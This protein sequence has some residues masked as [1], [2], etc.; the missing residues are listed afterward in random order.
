MTDLIARLRAWARRYDPRSPERVLFLQAADELEARPVVREQGIT[1]AAVEEAL[2]SPLLPWQR[3]RL[4][5]QG[6]G[7]P[8]SPSAA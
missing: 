3:K 1:I 2:G 8:P 6:K 5:E 4:E 7:A